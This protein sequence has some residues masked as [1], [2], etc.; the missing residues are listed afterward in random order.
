MPKHEFGIT[1]KNPPNKKYFSFYTPDKY[2]C[3]SIDDSYI[4]PIFY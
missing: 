4:E 3:I 1:Q 2:K